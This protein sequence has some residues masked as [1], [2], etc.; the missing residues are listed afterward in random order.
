MTESRAAYDNRQPPE[1]SLGLVAELQN[2]LTYSY[3]R[4]GDL[5]DDYRTLGALRLEYREVEE[6]IQERDPDAVRAEL[7]DL[8]NV[9]LRRVIELDNQQES[10]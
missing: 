6:A 2:R 4:Y 8:A 1:L 7:L 5:G 3:L 10:N 9:A